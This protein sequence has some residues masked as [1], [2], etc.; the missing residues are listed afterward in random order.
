MKQ[1]TYSKPTV[2]LTGNITISDLSISATAPTP[3]TLQNNSVTFNQTAPTYQTP[4][5][6]LD[7]LT[8]A[9]WVF[10]VHLQVHQVYLL[11]Q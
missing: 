11:T 10:L 9:D 5:L 3:P 2:S 8:I 1:P 6:T 4:V 7:T